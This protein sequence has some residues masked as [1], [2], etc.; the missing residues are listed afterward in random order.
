MPTR[1]VAHRGGAALWPEN[2]LLAFR[3]AIAAGSRLLEFDVHRTADGDVAVIHD[4]TLDRTTNASGPVARR[5]AAALRGVRLKAADGALLDEGV[6]MLGDV[7]AVAGAGITLLVEIKTP[8]PAVVYQRDG[9]R[10]TAVPGARYEGLEQ[11]VLDRLRA[12]GAADRA[13]IMAFNPDVLAALRAVAP[14]QATALLVD[15]HHVERVGATGADAAQWAAAARANYLGMH[16]SL[17]D[18]AAVAAA[19]AAGVAIGVFTVNDAA[20]MRRLA[21]LGVDVI[22]TDRPDLVPG[23]AA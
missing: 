2:S 3:N 18:A 15:R 16:W 6:P 14:A 13:L 12:A 8:G 7:L 23:A 22:I 20:A 17:C 9:E 10:I 1:Y 21:A 4:P 5:T 19:R 11:A